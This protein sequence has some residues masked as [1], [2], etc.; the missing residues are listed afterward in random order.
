M[1]D[2]QPTVAGAAMDEQKLAEIAERLSKVTEPG[3]YR[4]RDGYDI[5]AGDEYYCG[6]EVLARILPNARADANAVF[7]ADAP[8][9]IAWLL[10][11]VQRQREMLAE[12]AEA[13]DFWELY[14]F[15]CEDEPEPCEGWYC[16]EPNVQG[17]HI[18]VALRSLLAEVRDASE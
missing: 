4:T 3:W 8:A 15:G 11:K 7:I 9:D 13:L 12:C 6:Y 1:T 17:V 18:Q 5:G 16:L 14:D 10:G 2:S